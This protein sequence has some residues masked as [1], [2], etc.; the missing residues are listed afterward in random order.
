MF[1]AIFQPSGESWGFTPKVNQRWIKDESNSSLNLTFKF[2]DTFTSFDN[3][4]D[5]GVTV[6]DSY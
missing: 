3:E 6:T 4:R 1:M 5:V 2:K